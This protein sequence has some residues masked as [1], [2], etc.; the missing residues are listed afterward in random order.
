MNVIDIISNDLLKKMIAEGYVTQKFGNGVAV[1]NYTSKTQYESLWNDATLQCRGLVVADNGQIIARPFK[2]FFNLEHL[3]TVPNCS[4]EVYEKLD[5]SLGVIYPDAYGKLRI[6]TRGNPL[7]W[8]SQWAS[9]RLLSDENTYEAAHELIKKQLTPLVEIITP[10]NKIVVDYG[11]KEQLPLIGIIDIET[12]ADKPLPTDWPDGTPTAYTNADLQQLIDADRSNAEGYVVKWENG[13]R[14]KIKHQTYTR[15][16]KLIFNCSEK[17][18]WE[19][20]KQH[21]PTRQIVNG[22]TTEIQQWIQ[23]TEIHLNQQFS[24]IET[25][26]LVDLNSIPRDIPRN[27][28][29]AIVKTKKYPGIVFAMLDSKPYAQTIWAMIKPTGTK[30]IAMERHKPE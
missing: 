24:K 30:T 12:G 10:K 11:T 23:Q 2:K 6:T 25:Q 7:S 13:V 18:V 17:T 29:A 28:Q 4:Y 14:A 22:A 15:L 9:E 20:L 8:Q 5:G 21:K 26:A 16:H 1:L 19:L 3:E 27:Q